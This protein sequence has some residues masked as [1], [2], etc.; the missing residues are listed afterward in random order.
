MVVCDM[1]KRPHQRAKCTSLA[2]RDG[3]VP[4]KRKQPPGPAREREARFQNSADR[5]AGRPRHPQD[6]AHA[7]LALVREVWG[8]QLPWEPQEPN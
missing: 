7:G 8:H 5:H 6:A 1:Q 3:R 2:S 4:G